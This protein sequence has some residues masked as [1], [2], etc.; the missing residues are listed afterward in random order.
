MKEFVFYSFGLLAIVW[1]AVALCNAPYMLQF[2]ERIRK[3]VKINSEAKSKEDRV[4]YGRGMAFFAFFDL[5][6]GLWV[7]AGLFST[8]WPF[9]L[10]LRLFSLVPKK[11]AWWYMLDAGISLM[12]LTAMFLNK[13]FYG[14][15]FSPKYLFSFISDYFKTN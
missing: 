4:R 10:G 15:E 14:Y 7:W 11:K 8:Q 13:Y 5:M 3:V 12:L 6:Y 9:V 1:E 2:R